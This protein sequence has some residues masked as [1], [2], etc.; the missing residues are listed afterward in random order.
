MENCSLCNQPLKADRRYREGVRHAKPGPHWDY[1]TATTRASM[2]CTTCGKR[3]FITPAGL[4]HAEPAD[5]QLTTTPR[6][7]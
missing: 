7:K 5:H 6:K 3:G 2:H 1:H 4:K